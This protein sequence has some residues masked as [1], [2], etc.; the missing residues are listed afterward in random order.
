MGDWRTARINSAMDDIQRQHA[1]LLYH[2]RQAQCVRFPQL[3]FFGI[4]RIAVP[5]NLQVELLALKAASTPED[6]QDNSS[7]GALFS[8][9]LATATV[10]PMLFTIGHN[11]AMLRKAKKFC[12]LYPMGNIEK[13]MAAGP[14]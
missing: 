9:F 7:Y 14:Q 4:F 10:I 5:L 6:I 13:S 2:L 1:W 12:E 8:I 3:V 11:E